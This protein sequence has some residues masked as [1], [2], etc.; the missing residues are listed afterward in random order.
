MDFI[1]AL[2][3]DELRRHISSTGDTTEESEILH[4]QN[5]MNFLQLFK[6]ECQ[7]KK[8]VLLE[9]KQLQEVENDLEIHIC[10]P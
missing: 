9:L 8:N 1:K 10:N 5:H 2:I 3:G 6:A 7:L 4:H